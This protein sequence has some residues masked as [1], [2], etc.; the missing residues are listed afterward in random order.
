MQ[1]FQIKLK[2]HFSKPIKLQ[3]FLMQQY[4]ITKP[5]FVL[6]LDLRPICYFRLNCTKGIFPEKLNRASCQDLLPLY[7]QQITSNE[8]ICCLFI[9]AGS[10]GNWKNAVCWTSLTLMQQGCANTCLSVMIVFRK[11]LHK[12]ENSEVQKPTDDSIFPCRQSSQ[13]TSQKT[14]L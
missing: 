5:M 7:A 12:H 13:R 6:Y 9:I 1:V 2:Y 10:Q 8:K 14:K 11:S 3:K 4:K